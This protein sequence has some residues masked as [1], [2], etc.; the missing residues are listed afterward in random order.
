[1][2][3]ARANLIPPMVATDVNGNAVPLYINCHQATCYWLYNEVHGQP[4]MPWAFVDSNLSDTTGM[5]TRLAGY[6]SLALQS[7]INGLANG[8]VLI[9][10]DAQ[11][12]AKHSCVLDSTGSIAGY[13]QQSWFT[14]IGLPNQFT[15]HAKAD[16]RWRAGR[17]HKVLLSSNSKGKLFYIPETTAVEFAR[18]NF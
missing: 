4:P 16:I 5:M 2:L 15:Q 17:H 11:N 8:T 6:G 12:I 18:R 10:T 7:N 1:M 14:S 9:F 13:N 3:A